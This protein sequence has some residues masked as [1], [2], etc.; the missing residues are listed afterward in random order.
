MRR[1]QGG[2]VVLDDGNGLGS[3]D[4]LVQM[5]TLGTQARTQALVARNQAIERLLQGLAV[6]LALQAHSHG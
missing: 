1:C 2:E 3:E 6:E 4:L 5:L